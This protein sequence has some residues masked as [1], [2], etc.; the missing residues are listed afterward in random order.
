VL[1]IIR[2]SSHC[3]IYYIYIF[4][5]IFVMTYCAVDRQLRFIY[6]YNK[7]QKEI[8]MERPELHPERAPWI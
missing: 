7:K 2:F 6:I 5:D 1:G 4:P 3:S 8:D